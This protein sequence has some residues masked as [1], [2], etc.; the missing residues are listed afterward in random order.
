MA[1]LDDDFLGIGGTAEAEGCG[2]GTGGAERQDGAT[3]E[4]RD[5]S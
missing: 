4:H 2:R 5:A 1:E 3:I